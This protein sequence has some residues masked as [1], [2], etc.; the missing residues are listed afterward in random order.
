MRARPSRWL[1]LGT[2]AAFC[3]FLVPLPV[4]SALSVESW[5]ENGRFLVAVSSDTATEKLEVVVTHDDPERGTLVDAVLALELM[6]GERVVLDAGALPDRAYDVTIVPRGTYE[7]PPPPTWQPTP[8]TPTSAPPPTPPTA[9][10]VTPGFES[11]PPLATL[12]RYGV[13][14]LRVDE[15][16]PDTGG[17]RASLV[18]DGHPMF[19]FREGG[20]GDLRYVRSTDGGRAWDVPRS[21][22]GKG[23]YG[24]AG[25]TYWETA[26]FWDGSLAVLY[27]QSDAMQPARFPW[28]LARITSE[29]EVRSQTELQVPGGGAITTSNYVE[30][31]TMP[32]GRLL[33]FAETFPRDPAPHELHPASK[34]RV[35][36]VTTEGLLQDETTIPLE[37]SIHPTFRTLLA[38]DGVIHVVWSHGE[39]PTAD[40][41][42]LWTASSSDGG[43]TFTAPRAIEVPLGEGLE[44][45]TGGAI[46]RDAAVTS[47]GTLLLS[48][49][50][51]LELP[52]GEGTL[53]TSH[54]FVVRVPPDGEAAQTDMRSIK[55]FVGPANPVPTMVDVLARDERVWLVFSGDED[56][57]IVES[58]DAGRT[59]EPPLALRA[60]GAPFY[61]EHAAVTPHGVPAFVTLGQACD[62]CLATFDV[63]VSAPPPAPVPIRFGPRPAGS[64]VEPVD[65]VPITPPTLPT[66]SPA[67]EPAPVNGTPP[68]GAA[69]VLVAVATLALLARRRI[70]R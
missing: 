41:K 56:T 5:H 59:Y 39:T 16:L 33:L 44:G 6:A 28:T 40:A 70:H 58:Y 19:L 55:E 64:I 48:V 53:V 66:R 30:L 12:A 27:K 50:A 20:T 54:G 52:Y 9:W 38:A 25:W 43:A 18:A 35:W 17:Y 42:R 15:P 51:T 2:L 61:V 24:Y 1:V 36:R 63:V 69:M 4:A 14:Q 8:V 10:P 32:D 29:G 45:A 67:I 57:W 65:L 46:L 11:L 21:L 68:A 31:L 47:S 22:A 60:E 26:R 49:D 3:A 34:L 13:V 62:G 7:Q 23:P 37:H